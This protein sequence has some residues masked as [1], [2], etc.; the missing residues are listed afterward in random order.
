MKRD[1]I[2]GGQKDLLEF[3]VSSF[4]C[5]AALRPSF[6]GGFQMESR[7]RFRQ[8]SRQGFFGHQGGA[9]PSGR[10]APCKYWGLCRCYPSGSR[11]PS[12]K[13]DGWLRRV[14]SAATLFIPKA[15]HRTGIRLVTSSATGDGIPKDLSGAYPRWSTDR[16]GQAVRCYRFGNP[17]HYFGGYESARLLGG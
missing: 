8:S 9:E 5:S 12:V 2:I 4:K 17:P 1:K 13:S 14:S 16:A 10:Q 3:S 7:K 15:G 11:Q 6:Y